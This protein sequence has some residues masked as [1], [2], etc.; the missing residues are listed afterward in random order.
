MESING[1]QGRVPS[2]LQRPDSVSN[3][4]EG[5]TSLLSRWNGLQLAVQ[6]QWGGRDSH[7]KSQQLASDIFCWLSQ[8]KATLHVED[9]EN[10]LHECLLLSFNTEIEMAALRR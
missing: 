6:N 7:Q 5:I 9:L 1:N 2:N 8:S 10:M 4:Q 3:L